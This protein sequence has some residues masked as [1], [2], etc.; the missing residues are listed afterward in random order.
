MKVLPRPICTEKRETLR[1]DLCSLIHSA[2]LP[3]RI[4]RT[5]RVLRQAALLLPRTMELSDFVRSP[6]LCR[7]SV[8]SLLYFPLELVITQDKI[9]D[10]GNSDSISFSRERSLNKTRWGWSPCSGSDMSVVSITRSVR[11]ERECLSLISACRNNSTTA[12]V[13]K[14]DGRRP[15]DEPF[16]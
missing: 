1:F 11:A 12:G 9:G 4:Q 13:Y 16:N 3:W 7:V 14:I 5:A 2:T 8:T 10:S 6:Y 15:V